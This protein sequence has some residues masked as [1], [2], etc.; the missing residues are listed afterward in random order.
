M[1]GR[2]LS[3]YEFV[4]MIAMLFAT[5]AFSID[6]MLP[7]LPEIG[8]ELSPG[9]LN[10]AQLIVTSFILGMGIGIFLAG[11]LSD[12]L[13]RKPVILAGT[14]LYIF[15]SWLAWQAQ[16]LELLLAARILQGLGVA[17]PR[18]AVMAIIR[19]LYSGRSM[20]KLMSFNMLVFSLVPAIAP[21]M[22]AI[23]VQYLGWRAI[24]LSFIVFAFFNTVWLMLR[25]PETL[26][27][28]SRA[29][30]RLSHIIFVSGYAMRNEMFLL[31]TVVITLIFG[32]LMALLSSTQQVYDIVFDQGAAFPLWFG[33]TAVI[34]ATASLINAAL[35]ERL[36]M[37][38][39]ISVAVGAEFI[40]SLL[41]AVAF[42]ADVWPDGFHLPVYFL[43][44]TSIFFIIGLTLGNLHALAMEPMGHIA[45]TA[46]TIIGG[47]STVLSV[48][49]AVPIGLAFN[50][51]PIPLAAG[52]AVCCAI[53]Y[54]MLRR[55]ARIERVTTG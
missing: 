37:R 20:A 19:D 7:A 16:T 49:V 10:Q 32:I 9:D 23:I 1:T 35:V 36:G 29:P 52:S 15:A 17:G 34:A 51:T 21:L 30:F 3:L 40:L 18:I 25:Q 5:V 44:S 2:R 28:T 48:I 22:G 27:T 11:P 33:A 41:V 55:I 38:F 8:A 24:F 12:S 26:A 50:G 42:W 13:G 6:S 47:I 39:L 43:W 53:A 4:P 54:L 46:A 45:G 14:G 31:C